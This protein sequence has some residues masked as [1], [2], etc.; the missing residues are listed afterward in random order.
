MITE[1]QL[2]AVTSIRGEPV[3]IKKVVKTKKRNY[4]IFKYRDGRT[5]EID[6]KE[7]K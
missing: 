6:F 5:T 4:V 3:S 2:R 7:E 1:A